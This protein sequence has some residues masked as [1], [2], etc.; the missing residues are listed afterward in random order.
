[1]SNEIQDDIPEICDFLPE[2]EVLDGEKVKIDTILNIPL[3]FTGWTIGESD[4]QKKGAEEVLTLQFQR[5]D[6][7]KNIIFTGSTVLIEQIREF[8]KAIE[9]KKIRKRFR[10]VIKKIDKFYKFCRTGE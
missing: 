1:M 8:E 3:V 4:Y 6:G 7:Q 5:D 9:E 10:A 2:H